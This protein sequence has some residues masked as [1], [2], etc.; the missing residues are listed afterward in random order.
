M[1]TLLLPLGSYDGTDRPSDRNELRP[2]FSPAPGGR[3]GGIRYVEPLGVNLSAMQ[4]APTHLTCEYAQDPLGIGSTNP[5]LS[6]WMKDARVGARQ[7]AYQIIAGSAPGGSDLWDSG[8]VD[9]D[10]TTYITYAGQALAS[11]Q[12]VYWRVRTWDADGSPSPLSESAVFSIGLLEPAD[13]RARWI[14]I[15]ETEHPVPSPVGYFRKD[16][17]I[18]KPLGRATLYATAR[19]VY[20]AYANNA[21]IGEDRLT[22]GWSDYSIRIRYQTYDITAQ[23]QPGDN[24]LG[25]MLADGWY[26]GNMTWNDRSKIYGDRPAALAQLHLLYEDGSE[27]IVAT[28]DSW[29]ATNDG[30][31]ILSSFLHGDVVDARKCLGHWSSPH[32][33]AVDWQAALA[34]QRDGVKLDAQIGPTVRMTEQIT[35]IDRWQL[36]DGSWVFDLGQNMVGVVRLRVRGRSGQTL[37]VRHGEMLENGPDRRVHYAN[38]RCARATERFILAG[39][40]DV[41]TFEPPFTLHGFRYVEIA[42]IEEEPLP[43]ALVGVVLHSD[44]RPTGTFACSNEKLNK[45]QRNIVWG[46]RGNFVDV[47]TD[48]PQR[49]ERLGWMGDAQVFIRT[50]TF[51]MDVSGFFAR[52]LIDVCDAQLPGGA[53]SDVVPDLLT[54][55]NAGNNAGSGAPAWGDAGVICPWTAYLAYA[56]RR[57]LERCYPAMAKYIAFLVGRCDNY[58]HPDFGYGDWL[59]I[60]SKTPKDLIGTA[61]SAYSV[62]LMEKIA[63][64]LNKTEDAETFAEHF[65]KFKKAFNRAFVT[66]DGRVA[67]D[68]QTADLLALRFNLVDGETRQRVID[69]LCA[70]IETRGVLTTGFVGCNLL[71]PTLSEI[72]RDDLAYRLML[73]EKFPSWLFSVNHGATTIWERWDGWTIERGL[74]ADGMNSFN[75]YAYGSCGEWMYARIGGIDLDPAQPGYKRIIFRPAPGGGIT[76]AKTALDTIHGQ[77]RCEWSTDDQTMTAMVV[78]PPNTTAVFLTP[79]KLALVEPSQTGDARGVVE[80]QPGTHTLQ[81]ASDRKGIKMGT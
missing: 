17:K 22:P 72:G 42:G 46:Q 7:T 28:D 2:L 50:A 65:Q 43:E 47:P 55:A 31:V 68:S 67:G 12:R 25:L 45:L 81:F 62:S 24:A 41:E 57:V 8:K 60:D 20:T 44:T 32:D 51:N 48:C 52:W 77:V 33:A 34:Q 3:G 74:H 15:A 53:F 37:V 21:R 11:G 70:D 56:D 27:E 54:D 38:L 36:A 73:N 30:P 6:W 4:T 10:A 9:S 14:S 16:F 29:Q 71:L 76:W 40:G 39:T 26:V 5:R 66:P 35:P 64:I 23:L 63:T 79:P 75:H 80:L 19:G 49:D 69:H 18:T 78:V 1:P 13:W 59:A 61:Y 58:I